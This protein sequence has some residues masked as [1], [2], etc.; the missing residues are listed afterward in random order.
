MRPNELGKY[1]RNLREKWTFSATELGKKIGIRVIQPYLDEEFVEYAL[2]I[3]PRLKVGKKN[4]VKYGKWIIRVSLQ[5]VLPD[6]VI[7][8]GK[9]PTEVGS[10]SIW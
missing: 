3:P 8:R 6:V 7:W 10:G 1:I 5:G 9:A 2:S 4:G